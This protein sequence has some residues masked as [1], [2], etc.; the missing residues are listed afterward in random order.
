MADEEWTEIDEVASAVTVLTKRV[1][2]MEIILSQ[3]NAR[4][5]ELLARTRQPLPLFDD[6]EEVAE[7]RRTNRALRTN[8]P[9]PLHKARSGL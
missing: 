5:K 6:P 8:Q 9:T 2:A 1:E 3:I 7:I 4:T